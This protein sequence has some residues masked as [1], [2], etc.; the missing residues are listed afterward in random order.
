M[1][2]EARVFLGMSVA[3]ASRQRLDTWAG[4]V[5]RGQTFDRLV[6]FAEDQGFAKTGT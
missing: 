5:N 3:P 4:G 2:K 6:Q 1:A